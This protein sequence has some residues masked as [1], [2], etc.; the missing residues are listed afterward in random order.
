[1]QLLIINNHDYT[2]YLA[3]GGLHIAP[4]VLLSPKS[5]R[6]ARGNNV[7]DIVNRKDKLLCSFLPMPPETFRQ[8]WADIE[9]YVIDVTFYHPGTGTKKTITANV[10]EQD[11]TTLL[12]QGNTARQDG[13]SLNFIEL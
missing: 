8:F 3:E 10:G 1:M 13:F 4:Q 11:Y 5:G 9:P 2:P 12:A 6:N 7:I